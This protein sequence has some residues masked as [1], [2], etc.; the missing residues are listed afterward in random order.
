MHTG[1]L[2]TL[3]NAALLA[4]PIAVALVLFANACGAFHGAPVCGPLSMAAIPIVV[5]PLFLEHILFSEPQSETTRR[6]MLWLVAYLVSLVLVLI[7]LWLRGVLR[8]T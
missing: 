7:V 1:T 5:L 8:R 2:T 3:R 4:L 6:I